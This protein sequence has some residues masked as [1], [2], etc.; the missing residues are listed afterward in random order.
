[1]NKFYLFVSTDLNKA[2]NRQYKE[3]R[4][5]KDVDP[6]Y[7]KTIASVALNDLPN[8]ISDLNYHYATS[9]PTTKVFDTGDLGGDYKL[10]P[11]EGYPIARD[12]RNEKLHAAKIKM[13]GPLNLFGRRKVIPENYKYKVNTLDDIQSRVGTPDNIKKTN[14]KKIRASNGD[15][16]SGFSGSSIIPLHKHAQVMNLHISDPKTAFYY[17]V[18]HHILDRFEDATRAYSKRSLRTTLNDL[19]GRHVLDLVFDPSRSRHRD[20]HSSIKSERLKPMYF[21]YSANDPEYKN[22]LMFSHDFRDIRNYTSYLTPLVAKVSLPGKLDTSGIPEN[23]ARKLKKRMFMNDNSL[24]RRLSERKAKDII[25]IHKLLRTKS[26]EDVAKDVSYKNLPLNVSTESLLNMANS[27]I[28]NTNK[29]HQVVADELQPDLSSNYKPLFDRV[30]RISNG[31]DPDIRFLSYRSMLTGLIRSGYFFSPVDI[32]SFKSSEQ[33]ELSKRLSK[34]LPKAKVD[35][36]TI[37]RDGFRDLY[38]EAANK[39]MSASGGKLAI[40]DE[41]RLDLLHSAFESSFKD[42]PVLNEVQ[43]GRFIGEDIPRNDLNSLRNEISHYLRL[44]AF[45]VV[46]STLYKKHF[47]RALKDIVLKGGMPAA[48]VMAGFI[49]P[50]V[51]DVMLS[52]GSSENLSRIVK[53][54]IPS[55]LPGAKKAITFPAY[56]YANKMNKAVVEDCYKHVDS[57][58]HKLSDYYKFMEGAGTDPDAD[59]DKRSSVEKEGVGGFYG[60]K[61]EDMPVDPSDPLSGMMG[62]HRDIDGSKLAELMTRDLDLDSSDAVF[63]SEDSSSHADEEEGESDESESSGG[64]IYQSSI[65]AADN[66]KKLVESKSKV[67]ANKSDRDSDVINADIYNSIFSPL[68][69]VFGD[70]EKEYIGQNV[71][72]KLLREEFVKRTITKALM[73]G[74]FSIILSR[75]LDDVDVPTTLEEWKSGGRSRFMGAANNLIRTSLSRSL[76]RSALDEE[77]IV[78]T[79]AHAGPNTRNVLRFLVAKFYDPMLPADKLS[80][81]SWGPNMDSFI[82]EMAARGNKEYSEKVLKEF[83][84]SSAV[85]KK[86]TRF[87]DFL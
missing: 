10:A 72:D 77:D 78:N 22:P 37:D 41:I 51:D 42:K 5:S 1:M 55:K 71:S 57:L 65:A 25:I 13:P 38:N 14:F 24:A 43:G 69:K 53:D 85:T 15:F 68:D 56:L 61:L 62:S 80:Y 29:V 75:V 58:Y 17:S 47:I 83:K 23:I 79:L 70:T 44:S 40:K 6:G 60:G 30:V 16:V 84:P 20:L 7:K 3:T 48:E 50:F 18:H 82:F 46:Y 8:V 36:N 73:L 21:V 67:D 39:L 45:K 11:V 59:A 49:Q 35:I 52:L 32:D 86:K 33:S 31:V 4:I 27:D 74:T 54:Y 87:K 19:N 2:K 9:K 34:L 63:G 81:R 64:N 26:G 66:V 28:K 12:N 76:V